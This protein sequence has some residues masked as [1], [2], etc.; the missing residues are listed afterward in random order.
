MVESMT[1]GRE[2]TRVELLK[3]LG[4]DSSYLEQ[5]REKTMTV[6]KD[7]KVISF[8]EMQNSETVI[9]V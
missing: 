9:Q 7:I 1:N 6:W 2:S 4:E 5:H 8:Y 3:Q